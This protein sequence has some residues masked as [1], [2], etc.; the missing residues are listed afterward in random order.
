MKVSNGTY[1]IS[2]DVTDYWAKYYTLVVEDNQLVFEGSGLSFTYSYNDVSERYE[3]DNGEWFKI[4][5]Y[6]NNS[7]TFI[8]ESNMT[9]LFTTFK[10]P[11]RFM[12]L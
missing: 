10:T 11:E 4:T 3:N 6:S 5:N 1:S 8:D 12:K 9:G 2:I 7:F